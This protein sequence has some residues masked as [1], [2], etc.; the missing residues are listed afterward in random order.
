MTDD[1]VPFVDAALRVAEG[2]RE[3]GEHDLADKVEA[4]IDRQRCL[5]LQKHD[6][7]MDRLR[8]QGES[9]LTFALTGRA[10]A[11]LTASASPDVLFH[12]FRLEVQNGMEWT[13]IRDIK[14][15][16]KSAMYPPHKRGIADVPCRAF[17]PQSM[18]NSLAL[19][20][21]K[22]GGSIE[23]SVKFDRDC[24]WTATLEGR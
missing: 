16:G 4:L 22:P 9:K 10:G 18:E 13:A 11:V 3:L 23:I 20:T 5:E 21:C 19:P 14:V 6:R 2:A 24:Q 12:G 1:V 15:D 17:S 8:S 7:I